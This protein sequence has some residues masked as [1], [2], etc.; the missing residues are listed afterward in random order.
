VFVVIVVFGGDRGSGENGLC[1]GSALLKEKKVP[2]TFVVIAVV[3][4]AVVVVA[5]VVVAA[6]RCGAEGSVGIRLF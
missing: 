2:G 5:V 3:V 4:I 6:D 1:V